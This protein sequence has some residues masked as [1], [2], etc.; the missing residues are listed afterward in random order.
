MEPHQLTYPPMLLR[1]G[2]V[3]RGGRQGAG[4]VI[5]FGSILIRG[6]GR[7]AGAAGVAARV[8]GVG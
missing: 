2:A 4:C 8:V 3:H 7:A 5:G 6:G 1:H